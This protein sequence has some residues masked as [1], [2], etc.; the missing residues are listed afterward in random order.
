MTKSIKT[1]L[2]EGFLEEIQKE[3]IDEIV[4]FGNQSENRESIVSCIKA[5]NTK[6]ALAMI[7][8]LIKILAENIGVKSPEIAEDI[9][10]NLAKAEKQM[11]KA[12]RKKIEV[13]FVD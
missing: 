11:E 2:L 7:S 10:D 9:R 5:K 6:D 1:E 4:L 3:G 8:M 12:K 13:K